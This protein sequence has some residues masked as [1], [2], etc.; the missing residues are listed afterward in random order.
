MQCIFKR[1]F[2]LSFWRHLWMNLEM[3]HQWGLR[4]S[5]K[6]EQ[7]LRNH[8][9]TTWAISCLR[10][11]RPSWTATS[12][13]VLREPHWAGCTHSFPAGPMRPLTGGCSFS[14]WPVTW[15]VP[16]GSIL[17]PFLFNIYAKPSGNMMKY[18]GSNA[19]HYID[20]MQ[21]YVSFS[22]SCWQHSPRPHSVE[23]KGSIAGR[24]WSQERLEWGW[25]EAG[26]IT[27]YAQTL[28]MWTILQTQSPKGPSSPSPV[29]IILFS[30]CS[31]A[32]SCVFLPSGLAYSDSP[33]QTRKATKTELV[34]KLWYLPYHKASRRSP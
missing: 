27:N 22:P 9:G 7:R 5:H 16:Q 30:T 13:Q 25:Q 4:P 21:L 26:S 19:S 20:D 28:L 15:R 6:V 2:L 17:Q 32:I 10:H 29:S 14:L 8:A 12:W 31:L 3:K 1:Y 34:A 18:L 23:S 11:W 24:G 33:P